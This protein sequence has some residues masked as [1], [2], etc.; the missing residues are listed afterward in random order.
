LKMPMLE[1]R[2]FTER[3]D[4]TTTNV[5]I[6]NETFVKRF[7]SGGADQGIAIGRKFRGWGDDITI[8]GVVKDT[9]YHS[10][11][12]S[13]TPFFYV[14]LAQRY[15]RSMGV[16]VLARTAGNPKGFAEALRSEI[17]SVDPN[18]AVSQVAPLVDFMSA[19]YFVQTLGAN[20]LT[21][22]GTVSLLLAM[23]GLYGVTG[24][25]IAQ[26]THEIGIRMAIGARPFDIIKMVLKQGAW[27]AIGG[28]AGGL[29]LSFALSRVMASVLFEVS[30][31]DPATFAGAS[32]FVFA[33]ALLATW[34]PG[35]R[36]ARMNP[37]DALHWE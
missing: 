16:A 23:L 4:K 13:A 9:K 31:T 12:E 14:P 7:L 10:F 2:D 21:V 20:L 25:S 17:K 22:L 11:G 5:A 32:A 35:R 28:V 8:V 1:G 24:Y 33:F 37:L 18:I 26:R 34:L 6:V 19:S 36:A 3:D 15:S 29:A 30:S 27:L